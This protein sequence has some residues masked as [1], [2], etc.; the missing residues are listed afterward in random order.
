MYYNAN[1]NYFVVCK[2]ND[3]NI[4]TFTVQSLCKQQIVNKYTF[5]NF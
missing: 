5:D 2:N 1:K 4:E 3:D